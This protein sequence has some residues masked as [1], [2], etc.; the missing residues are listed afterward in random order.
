MIGA[1]CLAKLSLTGVSWITLS[2]GPGR[3]GL[4][5]R[6]SFAEAGVRVARLL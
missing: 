2:R 6:Y 5:G 1:G 3:A 4:L